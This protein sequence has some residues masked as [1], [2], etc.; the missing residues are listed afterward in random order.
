MNFDKSEPRMR[1][2]HNRHVAMEFKQP[3]G[4]SVFL[5][6]GGGGLQWQRESTS[7][8]ERQ[9]HAA[10]DKHPGAAALRLLDLNRSAYL[11]GDDV[12]I[13]L[14]EIY[15]TKTHGT[16]DL[17]ALDMK[18]LTQVYNDLAK[19]VGR[20]DVKAFKSKAEA[21]ERI[22][23]LGA[24]VATPTTEQ[25]ENKAKAAE[26][27]AKVA[28]KAAEKKPKTDKPAPAGKKPNK[29]AAEKLAGKA[30][31]VAGD[32]KPKSDKPRGQGIGAFCMELILK[33]KTNEDVLAA[34]KKQFPDAKTASA[35]IAWYRN[36]LKSEGQLK[37]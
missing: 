10:L 33:G 16:T 7:S 24:L 12:A 5:A 3:N 14:L 1:M 25:K 20:T 4:T 29:T 26:A 37:A 17:N 8:F 32:P 19:A 2:D 27:A 6:F 36:K 23:K 21:I 22:G 34:A 35:S 30:A 9:Y 11:P 31:K 18:A 15:M 13:T 28:T